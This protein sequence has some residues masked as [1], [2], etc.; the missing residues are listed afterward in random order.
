MTEDRIVEGRRREQKGRKKE[1]NERREYW[2]EKERRR[3]W[4]NDLGNRTTRKKREDYGGERIDW[5]RGE[6]IGES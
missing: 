3:E 2:R 6:I 5:R 1:G 4:E